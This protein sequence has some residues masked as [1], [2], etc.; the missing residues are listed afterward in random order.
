MQGVG[1]RSSEPELELSGTDPGKSRERHFQGQ[2]RGSSGALTPPL[3]SQG[4]EA[5]GG[6]S[7][8]QGDP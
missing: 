6:G 2:G 1:G 8:A 5:A 7:A 3:L 4:S